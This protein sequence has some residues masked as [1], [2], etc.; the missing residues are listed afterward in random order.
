[1]EDAHVGIIAFSY[2]CFKVNSFFLIMLLAIAF[3]VSS[4]ECASSKQN[5]IM[6]RA[7]VWG[8]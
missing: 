7:I 5:E 6:P 3:F 8:R 2:I 4:R 1:M